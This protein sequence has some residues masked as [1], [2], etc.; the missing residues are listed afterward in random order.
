MVMGSVLAASSLVVL[1]PNLPAG[2]QSTFPGARF[3]GYS[4]G[5]VVHVDAL[6]VG[7]TRVADVEE[8]FSGQAVNSGGLGTAINNEMGVVVQPSLVDKNSY[9]QGTGLQAGLLTSPAV[10]PGENQILLTGLVQADAAP[11]SDPAAKEIAVEI[12]PLAYASVLRG[13]AAAA[14][15]NTACVFGKPFGYGEGYAEDVQLIGLGSDTGAG[16]GS[17]VVAVDN[18]TDMG[19]QSRSYSY[20]ISNGDGTFG[21]VN[22]TRQFIAPVTLLDGSATEIQI[23]VLGEWIVRAIA[24]GKPGGAKMEYAPVG[25]TTPTTPVLD[26]LVGGNSI[27]GGGLSLQDL[28]G[29]T[30][31]TL[32]IA[33]ILDLAVGEDVRAIGGDAN[34]QPTIAAD[35][36][37]AAGAVDVARLRILPGQEA[38]AASLL[39][40]GVLDLRVGHF[41]ASSQVPEGGIRC[42]IPVN[43]DVDPNPVTVGQDFT[44][45]IS[46]PSSPEAFADFACD[47]VN[48]RAVDTMTTIEGTARF[49]ILEA[50]NGGVIS[51]NTVTWNDLGTW[52][53]GGPPIVVTIKA[54]ATGGSG[55]IRN[56][57]DV[58]ASAANCTGGAAGQALVGQ[59]AIN[60]AA[61]TGTFSLTGPR[62]GGG[63]VLPRTGADTGLRLA[64]GF[65]LIS[66]AF[67]GWRVWDRS[68]RLLTS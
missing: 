31:L 11:T 1:V 17:P 45:T 61:L 19:L 47:L 50:S 4:T 30:G 18:D 68:R 63:A 55:T 3:G 32:P 21:L 41:E 40:I 65:A 60:G 53:R 16:L 54:R 36:T 58:T 27:L 10:D 12:D 25:G 59:G 43:K 52:Q 22:E 62:V 9:A 51:G 34:S 46:I 14:W 49:Q 57:V 20:L 48:V 15:S 42:N 24:T 29:Q 39:G 26:V 2:A 6:N 13:D 38:A 56:V 7:T 66:L 8:A 64:I 67:A 33:G 23:K 5:A 44:Y 35:G 28:L 37:L